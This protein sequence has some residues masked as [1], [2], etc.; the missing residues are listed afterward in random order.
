M[1]GR[2][3]RQMAQ[4]GKCFGK[5]EEGA[6]AVEFALVALPF[7]VLLGVILET[8]LMLFAEYALQ[9]SVQ[10]AAR[11]VR[12]GQAQSGAMTAAAFKAKICSS[13]GIVINCS[14]KVVV[15]VRSDP[16]F[17]TLSNNLP[18]FLNVGTTAT[19]QPGQNSWACGG[20][21][22]ASAIVATYDWKFAFPFMNFLGNVSGN[23]ARRIV[24]FSL[25]QNEPFPVN[26]NCT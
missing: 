24:G 17:A 15:Y 1:W 10:N 22:Q 19:G 6:A 14:G 16:D 12:T 18:S 2:L 9:S 3:K 20:P 23:T 13:V 26:G 7:F 25:F 4:K 11:L 5:A 8:G 21:Q